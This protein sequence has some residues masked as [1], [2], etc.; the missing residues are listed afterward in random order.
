MESNNKFLDNYKKKLAQQQ[1]TEESPAD[2]NLR[3]E[4]K[5]GF[6]KPDVKNTVTPTKKPSNKKKMWISIAGSAVVFA[7]IVI[8]LLLF[9]NRGVE[10]IDLTGWPENDARLWANDNGV[11]LQI[12]QEYNDDFEA[13]KIISQSLPKGTKVKKGEFI[14]VVVSLGH[15]LSVT[16]PLPDFMSMTK[17]EI[18]AWAEENYMARVRITAEYSDEVPIGHVIRYEI[19]DDTVID[20][21]SRNT[22]IYIVVSKG[23][24][25]ESALE[26]V[27]PNFK[28]MPIGECYIFANENGLVLEV[29]EEYDDFVP[30]GSIISQSIKPEEKVKKGTEI[31]LVVSK[32]KM[33]TVPDFTGYS[34]E[35]ATALAGE[36]GIPVTIKER[37]SSAPPNTFISQSIKAGT[38]YKQG[39]ILEL[40]YS[41][42]NKIVLP[43]FVGQT[44]DAIEV[45]AKELN[46]QGDR[47]ST[48]LNSSHR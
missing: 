3:F 48:R 46:D 12:E 22:P 17:E 28:E 43:S 4:Q 25:D 19:N 9:F 44:R 11:I 42:D 31:T 29:E 6:V 1:Q 13:G 5:S 15:D 10:V 20:E 24:E 40:T 47:K 38:E 33:I 37:Y 26:V 23:P 34:K 14:K 41:I 35:R 16:L 45:W 2:T 30:A 21:V 36:L 8:G 27:V 18:E 32:G 7:A 39:D